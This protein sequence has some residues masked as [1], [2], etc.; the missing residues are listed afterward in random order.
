M[1]IKDDVFE[2]FAPINSNFF[3]IPIPAQTVNKANFEYL[4]VIQVSKF[5]KTNIFR[6]AY[7]T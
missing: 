4:M 1:K 7:K 5:T 2:Y 3:P 6:V